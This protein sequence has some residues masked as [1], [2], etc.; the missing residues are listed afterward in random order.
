M[1]SSQSSR[2]SLQVDPASFFAADLPKFVNSSRIGNGKCLKTFLMKLNGSPAA[3]KVYMRSSSDEDLTYIVEKL[4]FMWKTISPA[5]YPNLLPYQCWIKSSSRNR[6]LPSPVYLI[7][8]YFAFNLYDR[9]ATRP[10]LFTEEKIWII[11][12]LLKGIEM[13]HSKGII[14]GDIKPENIMCTSFNWVV[15]T[16]FA[17]HKPTFIPDDDTA[18]FLY[19]FDAVGRRRCY[20]APERFRK[21]QTDDASGVDKDSSSSSSRVAP[22][23][24]MDIFSL[25]CT[26]A[27]V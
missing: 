7:R 21:R 5:L 18:D 26:I 14:H 4:S 17:C 24:S 25:G 19:F 20:V 27:E 16:D 3:V 6:N 2:T 23:P 12:Q 11:F 9:L 10:F 22:V 1:G 15:I 8:Q 13:C